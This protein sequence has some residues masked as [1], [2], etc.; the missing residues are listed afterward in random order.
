MQTQMPRSAA[1]L[2]CYSL[3]G[4]PLAALS[5]PLYVIVPYFYTTEVG[6]SLAAVGLILFALRLFDGF[7]DPLLGHMADRTS[8]RLGRRK[9][10]VISTVPLSIISTY[11]IFVPPHGATVIHLLVW[12]VVFSVSFSALSLSY[13]AWGAELSTDYD[14][15]NKVSAFRE[16]TTLFGT[17]FA[18]ALPVVMKLNG[19]E[20]EGESLFVIAIFVAVLLPLTS[21]AAI[22]FVP[23]PD[24]RTTSKI[25][26]KDGIGALLENAP[27][28]RL[29]IS[30][31][32]NSFANALPATLFLFFVTDRLQA[33]E[34]RGILLLL[35]FAAGVIGVPVWVWLAKRYNKHRTWCI[36]MLIA[37]FFFSL[38]PLLR[39]EDIWVYTIIVVLTGLTL[40]SDLVLPSSL[41]ADV[42]DVDT[43]R[44]GEQRTGLYF[45]I[46]SIATQISLAAAAGL[47]FTL[48][49][50]AGFQAEQSGK[51]D[52]DAPGLFTLAILYGWLPVVV[53]LLAI[54]MMW[55][56]PITREKQKELSE[57]IATAQT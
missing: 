34:Q 29:V 55:Q 22:K 1:V 57:K 43:A 38:T 48:L 39:P 6:L 46:W 41:Q 17:V 26:L 37:C 27:F 13:T 44:T 8:S 21:L 7:I 31:I 24:N 32:L 53:K 20:K 30:F 56:F 45:A 18:T 16:V 49:D 3:P 23:E 50:V 47:A 11:M 52:A 33:E 54:S 12:G 51:M 14:E 5:L 4:L 28:I 15:R 19:Y 10:W 36:S 42:I 40:G 25:N 2:F 9:I 35:Y